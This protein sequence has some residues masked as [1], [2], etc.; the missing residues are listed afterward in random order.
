MRT[1]IHLRRMSES[2][3]LFADSLRASAQWNQTKRDWSR[4]LALSTRSLGDVSKESGCFVAEW[5]GTPVGTATT[6][7][8]GKALAWIG[9]L[10]VDPEF[11]G[12]GIGSALLNACLKYLHGRGIGCIKLD[13]TPQ[14]KLLY[15][16]LG[17]RAEWSLTRWEG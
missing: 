7:C 6:I 12:R 10:L 4:L 3:I 9:M 5:N 13:A 2:D 1:E 17:F 8:Y 14:G 16:R 11:R 15:E